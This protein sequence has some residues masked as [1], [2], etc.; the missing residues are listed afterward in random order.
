MQTNSGAPALLYLY[1]L[2]PTSEYEEAPM[3]PMEGMEPGNNIS[4]I[5]HGSITA[6]VTHVPEEEF[7]QEKLQKNV[8]KMEWLQAKAF[9]H[10]ETMNQLHDRYTTIPLKFGTIFEQEA[11]LAEMIEKYHESVTAQLSYLK[12]KEEWN[13]KTYADQQLFTEAVVQNSEEIQAKEAELEA[14]PAG[15]RF[16]EKKKMDQ[17]I[18]AQ[19][20]EQIEKH[21]QSFH[22]E[23]AAR[24]EGTEIKKNWEK[25]VTDRE[26]EMA[27]NAVYLIHS[28]DREAFIQLIEKRQEKEEAE[29]TGMDLECTGPWPAFHFS[30]LTDRRE[31]NAPRHS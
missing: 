6:V 12:G 23:L 2:I 17:F 28:E 30:G 10:H 20:D 27:W 5:E 26:K 8:E 21:C 24:S 11:N 25:R 29:E 3:E 19:A 4:F 13:V 22:D 16:F 9:H 18:E 7:S 1:A 15:R 31:Q 14:M